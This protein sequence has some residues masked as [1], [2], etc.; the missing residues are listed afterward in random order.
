MVHSARAQV[1]ISSAEEYDQLG[2]VESSKIIGFIIVAIPVH[3]YIC[4]C[5]MCIYLLV[6]SWIKCQYV[7][8]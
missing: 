3:M 7:P 1:A 5:C 4:N 6:V 2:I 8:V